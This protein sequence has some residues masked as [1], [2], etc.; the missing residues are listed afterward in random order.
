MTDLR[1]VKWDVNVKEV[2]DFE[3]VPAG[4]YPAMIIAS[5]KI[6]TKAGTGLMLVLTLQIIEGEYKGVEIID[7]INIQNPS[8]RCQEIGQG[9]VKRICSI[10]GVQ[11]PPV[12]M[13]VMYGKPMRIKVSVE[14]FESNTTGNMLESNKIKSYS[15]HTPG[16]YSA[17]VK[18]YEKPAE[19]PNVLLNNNSNQ[20][21]DDIPF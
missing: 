16:N 2:G 6:P 15:K 13:N 9:T 1:D 14:P 10:H 20:E 5:E 3:I 11:F 7:R 4:H 12:N 19:K 21:V 8:I 17:P 18:Q